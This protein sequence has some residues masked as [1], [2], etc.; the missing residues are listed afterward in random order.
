M[1]KQRKVWSYIESFRDTFHKFI[2]K[3]RLFKYIENISSKNRKF[4][5]KN[6]DIFIK[7]NLVFFM[8]M[9]KR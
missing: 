7:K 8:F 1:E 2:T 3:T 5:D 6:S 9:L 4:P